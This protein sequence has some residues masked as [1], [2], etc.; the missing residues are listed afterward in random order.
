MQANDNVSRRIMTKSNDDV[1][2]RAATPGDNSR[3]EKQLS[4]AVLLKDWLDILS[5]GH[6]GESIKGGPSWMDE[7]E[8]FTGSSDVRNDISSS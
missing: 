7:L 5:T 8:S 6:C 2:R 1:S 3:I 4:L